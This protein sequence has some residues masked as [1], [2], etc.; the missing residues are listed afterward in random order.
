MEYDGPGVR[1]GFDRIGARVVPKQCGASVPGSKG[2]RAVDSRLLRLRKRQRV[3]EVRDPF[4][5]FKLS[6]VEDYADCI[7]P[8]VVSAG[9]GVPM[10]PTGIDGTLGA[11]TG[12]KRR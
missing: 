9:S 2:A 4:F 3:P 8:M 12:C 7:P 5:F 11:I 10:G 6:L 1:C